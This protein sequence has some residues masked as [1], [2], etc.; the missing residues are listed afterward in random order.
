MWKARVIALTSTCRLQKSEHPAKYRA[1]CIQARLDL[2]SP[3][4]RNYVVLKAGTRGVVIGVRDETRI[5]VLFSVSFDGDDETDAQTQ[6][7]TVPYDTI[8]KA[9]DTTEIPAESPDEPMV[10]VTSTR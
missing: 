10:F 9:A 2:V 5:I 8:E 1:T 7:L 4:S 3:N 6:C